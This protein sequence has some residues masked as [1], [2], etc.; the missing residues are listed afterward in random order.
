MNSKCDN[1]Q[2]PLPAKQV[3]DSDGHTFCSVKCHWEYHH[4]TEDIELAGLLPSAA[5][6]RNKALTELDEALI[7]LRWRID[8][9]HKLKCIK[10]GRPVTEEECVVTAMCHFCVK[11]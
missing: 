10:C 3:A 2:Q 8:L 5:R 7:N 11:S 4:E 9:Y 6:R 1:C